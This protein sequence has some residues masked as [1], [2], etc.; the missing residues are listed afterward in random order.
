MET[1]L[2]QQAAELAAGKATLGKMV[3]FP[4]TVAVLFS[5]LFL[6]RK[7]LEARRVPQEHEVAEVVCTA[8]QINENY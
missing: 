7:K 2:A 4:L 8:A 1:G 5:L 3:F 6:M